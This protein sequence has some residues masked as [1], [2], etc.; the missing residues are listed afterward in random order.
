MIL[1]QP[2]GRGALREFIE[3]ILRAREAL[4]PA[5]ASL[6]IDIKD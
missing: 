3:A 6:G 2:G 5:L 4:V 1:E